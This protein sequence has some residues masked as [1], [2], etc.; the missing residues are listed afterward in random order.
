MLVSL[1]AIIAHF[2]ATSDSLDSAQAAHAQRRRVGREAAADGRRQPAALDG[3]SRRGAR[4]HETRVIPQT[5][6]QLVIKRENLTYCVHRVCFEVMVQPRT[7]RT[8]QAAATHFGDLV[9]LSS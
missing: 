2:A 8:R 7:G 3:S 6:A 5:A 1:A 9:S 4:R